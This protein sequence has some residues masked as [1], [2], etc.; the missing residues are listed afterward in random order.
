MNEI[1]I[2]NQIKDNINKKYLSVVNFE[3]VKSKTKGIFFITIK[4][5]PSPWRLDASEKT[6][7]KIKIGKKVSYISF[8]T[9]CENELNKYSITY[10]KIK[11]E[12]MLRVTIDEFSEI[13]PENITKLFTSI[14]LNAFNF[15]SFGCCG[16]FKECEK[17]G[18]CVHDDILYSTACQY[19]KIISRGVI[20]ESI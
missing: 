16:K 3:L 20:N 15:Q 11:S 14:M 12:N 7:A 19:R 2:F 4:A 10:S 6:L 1:D 8:A 13:S 18:I 17:N 5:S 9:C